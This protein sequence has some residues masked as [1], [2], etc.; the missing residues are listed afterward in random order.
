[1]TLLSRDHFQSEV[2]SQYEC[3][4]SEPDED[5]TVS[6]L[7]T[8][9]TRACRNDFRDGC[10]PILLDELNP[11]PP[12][13]HRV[14]GNRDTDPLSYFV[15]DM[16]NDDKNNAFGVFACRATNVEKVETTI[17]TTRMRSDAIIIPADDLFTKTVNINDTNVTISVRYIG[18]DDQP[19]LRWRNNT[20]FRNDESV[21]FNTD[22]FILDEPAQ[23]YH[24]GI[25]E[26][27]IAGNR[28][29]TRHALII[30]IVRGG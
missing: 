18:S 3:H 13:P 14:P 11:E 24:K 25:Y 8:S 21:Y 30:L 27:F 16:I 22:T 10:D 5:S 29:E 7:R 6:S 15:V 1:M 26:S 23:L 2:D 17:S 12:F 28:N 19:A 4:L 20:Q 9:H